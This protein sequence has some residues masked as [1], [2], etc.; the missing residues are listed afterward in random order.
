MTPEDFEHYVAEIYENKGYKVKVT[1]YSN[2]WGID[3]I[4]T[5]G[6]EKIAI[7]V[8]K[9]G[10]TK[11]KVNRSMI[12]GLY[13]AAAFQDCTSSVIATDGDILPDA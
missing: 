2:D 12:M 10:G 1:P 7:Q 11:S 6:D 4:A 8:K 3:V 5:Q 9:Y 13:G